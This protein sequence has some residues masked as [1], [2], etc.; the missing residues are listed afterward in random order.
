MLTTTVLVCSVV[1][2]TMF[3]PGE[4]EG[5]ASPASV[6]KLLEEKAPA[7]VTV[8]YVLKGDEGGMM[9]MF[10]GGEDQEMEVTGVV[11]DPAGVVL[12]SN[13]QMG[14]MMAR[15]S[16]MM[17]GMGGPAPQP[18]DIKILAGE[19]TV[20]VEGKIIARDS[21]LDLAWIRVSTAPEKPYPSVDLTKSASSQVGD[22]V[23]SVGRLGK[24]FDRAPMV[25]EFRV[26]GVTRK[27]RDMYV[28]GGAGFGLP[29]YNAAGECIG[30]S[31]LIMP[32]DEETEGNEGSF[33]GGMMD[34]AG[35][36]MI[37]PASEVQRATRHALES[38]GER[39]KETP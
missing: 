30:V 39:K 12:V 18:T 29:V 32:S 22:Y 33:L 9:G 11:I 23:Y 16:R 3:P 21:E 5:P 26:L 17:G 13:T 10:G 15:F 7:L 8:K 2:P 25:T 31:S 20:G 24:Y 35:A 38:V 27:P 19:D 1:A 34:S 37:I 4:P 36:M 14:G 6:R 28:A